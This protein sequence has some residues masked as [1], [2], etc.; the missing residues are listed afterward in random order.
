VESIL[1]A[2]DLLIVIMPFSSFLQQHSQDISV[3][4]L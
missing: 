3:K 4:H 1:E 2:L